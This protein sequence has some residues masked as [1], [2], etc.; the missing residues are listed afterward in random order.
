[1]ASL[2]IRLDEQVDSLLNDLAERLQENK[3]SIARKG[4]MS[5][6]QQQQELEEQRRALERSITVSSVEEVQKRVADSEESYRLSD[7]EY[8]QSLNEF[9]ARELGLVR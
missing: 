2:T 1:M 7:E 8:E 3:S 6:I 4:I 5:Y 9:F